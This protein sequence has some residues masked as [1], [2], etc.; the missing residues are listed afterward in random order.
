MRIYF[1]AVFVFCL[2]ML[3]AALFL[4]LVLNLAPCPL[5]VLQRMILSV[6]A[7][8]A[9]LAT[10]FTTREGWLPRFW[11]LLLALGGLASVGVSIYQT[12]LVSQPKDSGASCGPGLEVALDK[13]VEYLPQGEWTEIIYRSTASCTDGLNT[14]FGIEVAILTLPVFIILALFLLWLLFKRYD[15]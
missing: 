12:W 15:E 13:I 14:L 10:I 2:L 9:L 6:I 7:A 5:C 3:G 11:S 8:L 4:Q 1:F